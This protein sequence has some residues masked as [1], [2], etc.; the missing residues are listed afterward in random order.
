[1]A[2]A[3]SP[4][5]RD[6]IIILLIICCSGVVAHAKY[7]GG[8][9]T[10]GD[11][12]LISNANHMNA[13]GA[14]QGDWNKHFKLI[15]DIDLSCFV[16]SQFNM[17][18]YYISYYN[19]KAFTG[20]FDGNDHTIS[21]FT[22]TSDSE[23]KIGIFV[24]MHGSGQVRN[25][26]LLDPNVVYTGTSQYCL[27]SPLVSYMRGG[28]VENCGVKGGRVSGRR[29]VGPVVGFVFSGQV[30]RCWAESVEVRGSYSVG[31]LLGGTDWWATVSECYANCDVQG[32]S[33]VGG[34]IGDNAGNTLNSYADGR[35]AGSS[36]V[37]GFMGGIADEGETTR[38]CYSTAKVESGG[39]GFS[40]PLGW[41]VI[42]ACFWDIETSG[43]AASTGGTGLPTDQMQDANTFIDA[44]WD[45]INVW[46]IGENQTYPYLRTYLAGDINKDGTVNFLDIAIT[47][48]Q[49]MEG[50]E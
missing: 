34:C 35:V 19:R 43:K 26:V 13:V 20:V 18:G 47:A 32:G 36:N 7:G 24:Y 14:N 30:T 42:E 6:G 12:Y 49:W 28:S 48:N 50:V 37:G 40:G 15:A 4:S 46:N 22:Y 5:P 16:E 41:G 29:R 1:M 2:K 33:F 38:N 21:N 45:F 31:G 25:V 17:I 9:G 27:I 8:S 10:P 39:G 44:G 11:P 23:D 3:R